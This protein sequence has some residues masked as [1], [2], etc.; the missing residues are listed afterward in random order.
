M[1]DKEDHIRLEE[2]R[3]E[4]MDLLEE[5]MN[6]IRMSGNR[7]VYERAKSYWIGAIDAGLGEGQYVDRYEYTMAK[8]IAELDPGPEV[9]S[10]YELVEDD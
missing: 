2:I 5:S 3:S 10:E 4:M 8:T 1:L 9:D 6:I 7:S